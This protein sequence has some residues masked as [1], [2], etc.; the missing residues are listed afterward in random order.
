MFKGD[1]FEIKVSNTTIPVV[2]VGGG[3]TVLAVSEIGFEHLVYVLMPDLVFNDG[4]QT[5][6]LAKDVLVDAYSGNPGNPY[7][8]RIDFIMDTYVAGPEL[9]KMCR[10]YKMPYYRDIRQSDKK[11]WLDM[12]RL[13][14]Y[15]ADGMHQ[16]YEEYTQDT[17]NDPSMTFLGNEAAKRCLA[18]AS[19]GLK[20]K[21][22]L[23]ALLR[24]YVALQS[25]HRPG[26][27]FEFNKRNVGVDQAG[28][29]VLRDPVYDSDITVRIKKDRKQ[30]ANQ[31]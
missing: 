11:A 31:D 29:L 1:K 17:G 23:D 10:I 13:H 22:L 28:N 12:K 6:D 15:R 26:L 9:D 30:N 8:P 27:T 19:Q 18:L 20:N 16:V 21:A 24:L 2:F 5:Q 3:A 4:Y 25:K 14:K 7:L